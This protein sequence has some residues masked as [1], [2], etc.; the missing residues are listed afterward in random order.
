V[1]CIVPLAG[2]DFVTPQ[3][4]LRPLFPLDGV[5]LLEAALT[6]RPWW[7][8]GSLDARGLVFVIREVAGADEVRAFIERRFAG[9]QTVMLSHP[10]GGALMS[11][12]A[13]TALLR[14]PAAPLIVDL[15]DILYDGEIDCHALFADPKTAGA[16]PWFSSAE[17]CYSYLELDGDRVMRTAEKQ[18]ISRHASAGT[19]LF[20]DAATFLDAAAYSLRHREALAW[21]GALYLCPAFNGLIAE[22]RTVKAVEV[23]D[24]RPVGKTFKD[25]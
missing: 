3:F 24:C 23:A 6:S 2:P 13:A 7:R 25:H 19:Y 16:L 15:V 10:S 21:R 22:R 20:R 14:E 12:L 18:V 8:Q 11:A 4:G 5:P 9:A 17:D 1:N